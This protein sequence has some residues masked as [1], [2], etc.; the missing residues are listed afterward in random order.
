MA[1]DTPTGQPKPMQPGEFDGASVASKVTFKLMEVGPPSP[2][3]I[4]R[5]DVL[6]LSAAT[7]STSEAVTV[8]WRLMLADG[9]IVPGQAI[10]RPLN[11]RVVLAVTQSLAEGFLLS[12]SALASQASTRGQTFLRVFLNRGALGSGNPGQ[13]LFADY[14]TTAMSGG[15]PGGR[16]LSPTEGPGFIV[17]RAITNPAAGADWTITVPNNARW[18]V[19]AF[20]GTLI[21]AVAVANRLVAIQLFGGLGVA[22]TGPAIVFQT[23]GQTIGYSAASVTPNT[24]AS[25]A[26]AQ[27]PLPE[28]LYLSGVPTIT[29]SITSITTNIQAADQWNGL[30]L[31]LEEWLDNV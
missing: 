24:T 13:M 5:D 7:S 1:I 25:T 14:V 4:G 18:R 2:L 30:S 20:F 19:I 9:T 28:M 6:V 22:Y 8:N 23:A 21:A 12:I 11:T 31:L 10:V 16:V 15:Y 17:P 29:Q 27:L 26:F 3:Y